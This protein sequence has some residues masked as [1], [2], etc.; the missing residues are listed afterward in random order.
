MVMNMT[1]KDNGEHQELC[2]KNICYNLRFS[3]LWFQRKGII[4]RFV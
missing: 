2:E 1:N 3:T 4:Q